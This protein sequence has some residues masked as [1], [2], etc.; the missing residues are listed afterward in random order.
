MD[1]NEIMCIE[2]NVPIVDSCSNSEIIYSVVNKRKADI[3]DL[4]NEEGEKNVYKRIAKLL[5]KYR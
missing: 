4:K 1:I 5:N 2:K 3:S